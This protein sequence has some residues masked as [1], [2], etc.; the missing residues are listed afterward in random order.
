[1]IATSDV[2]FGSPSQ[3][4]FESF[5]NAQD[6]ASSWSRVIPKWDPQ[7][8]VASVPDG[9]AAH[10]F[11]SMITA[12][13]VAVLENAY[14]YHD[15]SISLPRKR[16][17]PSA[18]ALYPTECLLVDGEAQRAY[19][20]SFETRQLVPMSTHPLA[21]SEVPIKVGQCAVLLLSCLWRSVRRYGV[22]GYRY[23]LLDAACVAANC[24]TLFAAEAVE[25]ELIPPDWAGQIGRH[26]GVPFAVPCVA[27][28]LVEKAAQGQ[29][30]LPAAAGDTKLNWCAVIAPELSAVFTKTL[31]F[32][33]LVEAEGRQRLMLSAML[34]RRTTRLSPA[35]IRQRRSEKA[36]SAMFPSW[37]LLETL[38]SY[39]LGQVRGASAARV[40]CIV[41]RRINPAD[42]Y[43]L[44]LC[45]P[46]SND[47]ADP[48]RTFL[49]SELERIMCNQSVARMAA[50]VY[51]YG[52]LRASDDPEPY[53]AFASAVLE[54]GAIC[55][56][57]YN[58]C[59]VAG[60]GTSA[61][62]AF[63]DKSVK[64]IFGDTMFVPVLAQ[65]IG[66]QGDG[67]EPKMDAGN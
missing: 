25:I 45:S 27:G 46:D 4:S 61:I 37:S 26:C 8:L 36:L 42:A 44:E 10:S 20:Y 1:V 58:E 51:V 64:A 35:N 59:A 13:A 53:G 38:H 50:A 32:H 40:A 28:F 23:A 57:V 7:P 30:M 16:R 5:L 66:G 48:N 54:V 67:S 56:D 49:P 60:I 6:L 11:V 62:G 19:Y 33:Q 34:T 55:E 22:R 2:Q 43:N 52:Y 39:V 18:G 24:R 17:A 15:T 12:E 31:G 14:G 41:F 9:P 63:E 47:Q 3:A 29:R 21:A 65:V